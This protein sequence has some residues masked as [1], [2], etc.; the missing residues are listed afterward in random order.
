MLFLVETN[1]AHSWSVFQD[2]ASTLH[3]T[4]AT[5][6][7]DA[8]SSITYNMRRATITLKGTNPAL[9]TAVITLQ[10]LL[11]SFSKR[12]GE[13]YLMSSNA[14]SAYE[15]PKARQYPKDSSTARLNNTMKVFPIT[16]KDNRRVVGLWFKFVLPTLPEILKQHLGGTYTAC[17]VRRGRNKMHAQPC[18]QVESP[19]IPGP[20]ALKI[21]THSIDQICQKVNH[22]PI[23]IH[24]AQGTVRKL[25][26]SEE[27]DDDGAGES[28]ASQRLRFNFIRPFPRPGM[29][30]SLGLLC[31]KRVSATLGGY[32]IIDGEK[33]MLTSDHFVSTAQE[34]ANS[35]GD[36]FNSEELTS[37]SRQDLMKMEQCLKQSKRDLDIQINTEAQQ[38]GDDEDIP[39]QNLSDHDVLGPELREKHMRM[40]DIDN[41]LDQVTKPPN[42]YA[43]GSIFRRSVEPRR[44]PIPRSLAE[45]IQQDPN[46][47]NYQM[48]WSL[49]KLGDQA[50]EN[51]HKYRSNQDALADEY[52]DI[53]D[54]AN[55]PGQICHETCEVESGFV[56]FYVGQGSQHRSGIVNIPMLIS[57]DSSETYAWAIMSE[58][59]D[60]IQYSHVAGD[61]GAWIIRQNCN[62]LIGQVHG[63]S[64]GKVL[65]TPID[66]IFDDLYHF[67]GYYPSLSPRSSDPT[68]PREAVEVRPLCNVSDSSCGE[69]YKWL[70][71]FSPSSDDSAK[72]STMPRLA[73][74]GP[75]RSSSKLTNFN[76]DIST[77]DEMFC[78]ESCDS[79]SSLPSLTDSLR[80]PEAEPESPQSI[81][82][83]DSANG[84]HELLDGEI[85]PF[86]ALRNTGKQTKDRKIPNLVLNEHDKRAKVTQSQY[87]F[88]IHMVSIIKRSTWP[89]DGKRNS[90]SRRGKVRVSRHGAIDISASARSLLDGLLRYDRRI[91]TFPP[92]VH[93]AQSELKLIK[94]YRKYWRCYESYRRPS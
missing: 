16:P 68:Q 9:E 62:K 1:E 86:V 82:S 41:L 91:S 83:L 80:S 40:K 31:S 44:A 23:P 75:G 52:V 73:K 61:S 3:T 70:I 63:Y 4:N 84:S 51:R 39:E 79:P 50:G 12:R 49:C 48:D 38:D 37:P 74:I 92:K 27:A 5:H 43:V 45:V 34:P 17:L 8:A 67:C 69:P 56:V 21:L 13:K 71:K 90:T 72:K 7:L 57:K 64:N 53:S 94:S 14:E 2:I 32:V 28:A 26:G 66:V 93:G 81:Q 54:H 88:L 30:A 77:D 36:S 85:D 78:S 24:F 42:D 58:E 10:Q 65:F 15:G 25:D 46:T 11:E 59:G 19:H 18:I 33:Y 76:D 47:L 29:G 60:N 35:D 22:Q 89:I 20:A 87:G 6:S 55:Q